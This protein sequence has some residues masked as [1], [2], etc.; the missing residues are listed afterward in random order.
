MP[1][2]PLDPVFHYIRLLGWVGGFPLKIV[3]DPKHYTVR[4]E[5]SKTLTIFC[6]IKLLVIMGI[7]ITCLIA[8]IVT[9]KLYSFIHRAVHL[10][11]FYT[12][13][14]STMGILLLNISSMVLLLSWAYKKTW[15]PLS[16]LFRE[17]GRVPCLY[18]N[19][20]SLRAMYVINRILR[21]LRVLG[22]GP[23]WGLRDPIQFLLWP[24]SL[25]FVLSGG[26]GE[27]SP[28]NR[29]M[30]ELHLQTARKVRYGH[31]IQLRFGTTGLHQ[32][33]R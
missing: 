24:L 3:P 28:H 15:C 23:R 32:R 14:I 17:F 8:S 18:L 7:F 19:I 30:S 9:D 22:W 26:V 27:R 10:G 5:R 13:L 6:Y 12:D 31:R 21:L 25:L 4:F 16:R 11:M 1:Q 29:S 33:L 20:A 2:T